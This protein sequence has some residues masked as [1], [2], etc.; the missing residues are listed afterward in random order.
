MQVI[1]NFTR[2]FFHGEFSPEKLLL[3]K[4]TR[5]KF[6]L[7]IQTEKGKSWN[8]QDNISKH[9]KNVQMQRGWVKSVW[10]LNTRETI[11]KQTILRET[12][13]KF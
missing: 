1:T 9:I 7:Q 6:P 13:L 11:L 10:K 3:I 12:I 4:W 2:Q 8:I 5:T